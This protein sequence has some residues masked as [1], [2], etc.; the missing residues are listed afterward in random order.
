[1]AF[2][3]ASRAECFVQLSLQ[4]LSSANYFH[5]SLCSDR[6]RHRLCE[7]HTNLV[8]NGNTRFDSNFHADRER[9]RDSARQT[10]ATIRREPTVLSGPFIGVQPMTDHPATSQGG[11]LVM[12]TGRAT[13]TVRRPSPPD[14]PMHA[15][16]GQVASKWSQVE[17][18]LDMAIW[19]L[20]KLD[21]KTGASRARSSA[22]SAD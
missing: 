7:L 8:V 14:H 15:L 2:N 4:R 20:A 12:V 1:M 10:G 16:A 5:Y 18:F 22:R 3:V 6:S 19:R 9:V 13:M 21:D 11:A 17:H